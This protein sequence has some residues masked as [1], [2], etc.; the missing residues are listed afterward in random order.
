MAELKHTSYELKQMQSLPLD[1]KIKMTC[2]RIQE[3]YDYWEGDVYVSF[4]GG[5]DSTV[6]MD[7]VRNKCG[8]KDVPIVF[9]DTGLEFPEI[10]KMGKKYA[11]VILKPE[12]N[13]KE[14]L[15]KC[16]YPVISKEV[17]L[18]VEGSNKFL[19]ER[20]RESIINTPTTIEE[21]QDWENIPRILKRMLGILA[22]DNK[23]ITLST[24]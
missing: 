23:S 11:N 3:W 6:L 10:K 9:V 22:K 1:I 14:I 24:L 4:S 8:L 13:F 2:R 5:K 19:R 12:M 17:A 21:L 20:E 16:G 15:K 18:T 7:L